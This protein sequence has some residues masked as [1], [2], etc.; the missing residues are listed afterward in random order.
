MAFS[1][2]NFQWPYTAVAVLRSEPHISQG[3]TALIQCSN[4][5]AAVIRVASL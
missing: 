1:V 4:G 2:P 5:A 3:R